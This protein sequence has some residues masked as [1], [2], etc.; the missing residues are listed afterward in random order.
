MENDQG[1]SIS[2]FHKFLEE[3]DPSSSAHKT[4]LD[5]LA[6]LLQEKRYRKDIPEPHKDHR[7]MFKVLQSLI[8]EKGLGVAGVREL[9]KK[10]NALHKPISGEQDAEEFL[11]SLKRT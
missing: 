6:T 8:N 7:N 11:Q 10:V 9:R 4:T 2:H 3:F 1:G 5:A